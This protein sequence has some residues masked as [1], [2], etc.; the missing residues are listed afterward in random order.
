M[1][2]EPLADFAVSIREIIGDP[3]DWCDVPAGEFIFGEGEAQQTLDLPR[4][5][6]AKYPITYGQFQVFIDAKDGFYNPQCWEVLAADAEHK[7]APS[8]QYWKSDKHPRQNVSWYEAI[9]FSR[10]LSH[11]LLNAGNVGTALMSSAAYDPMN[12]ATWPIRLPTEAEWEKAA[13]GTDGRMYAW[14]NELDENKCATGKPIG[15]TTPVDQYPNGASPYGA[16]DMSGNVW[17]WSLSEETEPYYVHRTVEAINI[18]S[19]SQRVLRGGAW[20]DYFGYI[21]IART[22]ARRN[23]HPDNRQPVGFGAGFRICTS[24]L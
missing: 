23:L 9:A 17:E 8:E 14:G 20:S 22:V 7:K 5:A 19:Y 3:F 12:P 13:R 18:R 24:L 10:W 2:N 21:V 16:L 15:H 11:Q 4:F 6:I 1:N